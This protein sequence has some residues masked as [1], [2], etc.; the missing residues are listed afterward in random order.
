[1]LGCAR[2][3]ASCVHHGQ[4][5]ESKPCTMATLL[6]SSCTPTLCLQVV[7][8]DLQAAAAQELEVGQRCQVDPGS[9]RGTVRCVVNPAHSPAA[10]VSR[11]QVKLPRL[12]CRFVGR[13]E[14]LPKGFW[15]G[16][17]FDEPV[18]KNNGTVKGQKF[19]DCP[20]GYGGFQRPDTV[21]TGDFP[22]LDVFDEDDEI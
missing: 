5:T 17:Q 12:S 20:P 2:I 4:T 6:L 11:L 7:D 14:G 18:G 19:F 13:C 15:V 22:E 16:V 1:M 8:D 3:S 10:A 21:Q 9:R